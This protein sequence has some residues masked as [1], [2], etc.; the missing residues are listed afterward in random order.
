MR[1]LIL[2][3]MMIVTLFTM[4]F[5]WAENLP[6][7]SSI[8]VEILS[9]YSYKASDGTTIVLGE[10]QNKMDSP[11]N[12]VTIGVTF[13]DDNSHSIEYKTGT[14]LLQVVPPGGK[15]PFQYLQLMQIRPLHKSR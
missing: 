15:V 1:R 10:V 4:N 6:P 7:T 13:M 5:V 3:S 2:S 8:Q 9:S 12:A 14:T 11:V